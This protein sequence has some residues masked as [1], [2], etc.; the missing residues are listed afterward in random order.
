MEPSSAPGPRG[1]E[2]KDAIQKLEAWTQ[3]ER[4]R[5]PWQSRA[6]SRGRRGSP[7]GD[8]GGDGTGE[9]TGATSGL[10]GLEP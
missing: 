1:M 4:G 10:A 9:H 2:M 7:E 5:P 6:G 8:A 3:R